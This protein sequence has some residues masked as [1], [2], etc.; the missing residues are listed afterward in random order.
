L[1][2][3]PSLLLLA[4]NFLQW[5]TFP[6]EVLVVPLAV[7]RRTVRTTSR[8][9]SPTLL[10]QPPWAEERRTKRRF[11]FYS[12]FYPS[13]MYQGGAAAGGKVPTVTPSTK[14]RLR[15]LKLTRIKD[16]MLMETEVR[17]NAIPNSS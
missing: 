10:L 3:K 9:G 4:F 15:M 13:P 8:R 11:I 5:V 2:D 7:R 6:L 14:C 17:E 12:S 1:Y 16:Y